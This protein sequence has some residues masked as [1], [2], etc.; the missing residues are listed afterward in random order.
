[1]LNNEF[2][3]IQADE[4]AKRLLRQGPDE[5]SARIHWTYQLLYGRPARSEELAIGHQL[6]AKSGEPEAE[7]AWSDLVH[8][9]LCANEFIYVD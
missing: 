5:E 9:L 2:V 6:L 7:S 3:R 1:M 4:L 8:V